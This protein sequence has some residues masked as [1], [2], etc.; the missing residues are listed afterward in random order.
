MRAGRIVFSA[1]LAAALAFSAD[2]RRPAGDI[3]VAA[4]TSA[5]EGHKA[6]LLMFDASW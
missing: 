2:T 6:I 3:L 4:K 5:A 1:A